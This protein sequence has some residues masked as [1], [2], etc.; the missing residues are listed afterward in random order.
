M[1]NLANP[2][3]AARTKHRPRGTAMS[4]CSF[5]RDLG[6][7]PRNYRTPSPPTFAFE[8]ISPI[9]NEDFSA[10]QTVRR[11]DAGHLYDAIKTDSP[12]SI[13]GWQVQKEIPPS[14][15]D[16]FASIALAV[17]PTNDSEAGL[18]SDSLL[19]EVEISRLI[20]LTQSALQSAQDRRNCVLQN[21]L[22][23]KQI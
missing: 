16:A 12:H 18:S 1:V 21:G 9:Y 13:A 14:T 11:Q 2:P 20:I 6:Q 5:R 7:R 19:A 10:A 3:P 4:P 8:P 22:E 17:N 15:M 23:Q